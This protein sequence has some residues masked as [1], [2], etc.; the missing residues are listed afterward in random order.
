MEPEFIEF[1]HLMNSFS[2]DLAE[3]STSEGI[4][5]SKSPELGMFLVIHRHN[6]LQTF[7]NVEIA[8]RLYL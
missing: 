6:M 5:A 2:K 7:P 3:I 8:L 4:E 1:A